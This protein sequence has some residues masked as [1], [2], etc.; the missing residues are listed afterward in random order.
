MEGSDKVENRRLSLNTPPQRRDSQFSGATAPPGQEFT[1][2]PLDDN[3]GT[4]YYNLGFEPPPPY[5][6]SG[7]DFGP[8][9]IRIRYSDAAWT[10]GDSRV[11][12]A[13]PSI[14]AGGTSKRKHFIIL[15]NL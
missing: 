13:R 7:E 12:S 4:F 10:T 14:D 6:F 3:L 15:F 1:P 2:Y 11:G 5:A 9:G 8:D